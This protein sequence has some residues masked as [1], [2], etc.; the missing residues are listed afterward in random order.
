MVERVEPSDVA[1]SCSRAAATRASCINPRASWSFTT[2][3][4][5]FAVLR[6]I[7]LRH[8]LE[9]VA[10]AFE[11]DAGLVEVRRITASPGPP[12]RFGGRT[13]A[14]PD[15]AGDDSGGGSAGRGRAPRRPLAEHGD[16]AGLQALVPGRVEAGEQGASRLVALAAQHRGQVGQGGSLFFGDVEDPPLD[17]LELD[18]EIPHRTEGTGQPSELHAHV[19]RAHGQ[20]LLEKRQRRPRTTRG[21][22]HVVQLL[23]VLPETGTGLVGEDGREVPSQHGEGHITDRRVRVEGRGPQVGRGWHPQAGG[24]QPGL[25]FGQCRR[26]EPAVASQHLDHRRQAFHPCRID[27]D[28]HPLEANRLVVVADDDGGLVERGLSDPV[29]GDGQIEGAP[30]GPDLENGLQRSLA[31]QGT[32]PPTHR[33]LAPERTDAVHGQGLG[34]LESPF[35]PGLG[36]RQPLQGHLRAPP[37]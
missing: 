20:G 6:V 26:L 37:R 17:P 30:P 9:R 14:G 32:Q 3:R 25:E 22:P 15:E 36:L 35:Q 4:R 13:M 24:K 21:H 10:E 28:L 2:W 33:A 31:G 16:E 12:R 29:G 7:H 23:G 8:E 11:A 27:L 1:N 19:A 18:I 5:Y 34:H